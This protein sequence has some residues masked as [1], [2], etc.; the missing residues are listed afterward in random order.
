MKATLENV[1]CRIHITIQHQP[2]RRAGMH[3]LTQRLS[4]QLTTTGAHLGGSAGVY[5]NDTS[6]SFCRFADGHLDT[7]RPRHVH[8]ALA[9][10]ATLAHLLRSKLFK[11]DHLKTVN[12]FATFLMRKI[13]A[14]VGDPLVYFG[15]DRFLFR[16]LL[17]VLGLLGCVLPSLD[18]LEVCFITAVETRIVDLLTCGEGGKR[19]ES[20]I[21]THNLARWMQFVR[22]N[23]AG[24]RDEPLAT[25]RMRDGDSFRYPF[26]R[27][28]QD[29]VHRADF[30]KEE[31]IAVQLRTVAVLRILDGVVSSFAFEMGK[32][33]LFIATLH[34]LEKR[35]IRQIDAHLYILEE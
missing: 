22:V 7:L 5:E 9:H 26:N 2:T 10:P 17:P 34:T 25:P 28:M 11:G 27:T 21:H 18:A 8:D 23:L 3:T 12:Q 30:R 24:K 32:A 16:I 19:S 4:D 31:A 15:K 29:D 33:N 35:L 13:T 14:S 6:A 20:N 1:D